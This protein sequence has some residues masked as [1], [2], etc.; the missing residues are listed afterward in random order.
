LC[1]YYKRIEKGVFRLSWLEPVDAF[2]VQVEAAELALILEG[3]D[4]SNARRRARFVP[5]RSA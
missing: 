3:I 1:L 4:L 2:C 5:R